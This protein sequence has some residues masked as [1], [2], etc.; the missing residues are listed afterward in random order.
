MEV[1]HRITVE[2]YHR[3]VDSG[4]FGPEPRVELL[5]GVIVKKMTKKPPHNIAYDLL[6]ASSCIACRGAAI[7]VSMGEADDDRGPRRRAEPGAGASGL[8]AMVLRGEIRDYAGRRR[9]P[10]EAALLAEVSHTSYDYDRYAKWVT[11]AAARVPVYWIIDLNRRQLEVHTEPT[12]EGEAAVYARTQIFGPDD[13]VPLIL[14]GREV[15][16]FP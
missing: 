12:G 3:I 16:R 7:S 4:V 2:E 9:T 10:A 14:D 13:E 11:Y 6:E 8:P 1:R 15:G 5:E